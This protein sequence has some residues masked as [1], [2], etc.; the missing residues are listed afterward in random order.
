MAIEFIS[1]PGHGWLKVPLA[2]YPD[3]IECGTG[4][5][6]TSRDGRTVYLEEDVEASLFLDRHP[7]VSWDSIP[8]R[9]VR[10]FD[11]S[12]PSIPRHPSYVSPFDR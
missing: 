4:Y 9:Y 6:Y 12:L 10:A 3:A 7:G 8:K 11:K 2:D 1:D 5:G